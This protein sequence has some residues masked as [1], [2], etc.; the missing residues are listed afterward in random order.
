MD[1]L[2]ELIERHAVETGSQKAQKILQYWDQERAHF[3]QVCPIEM[4]DKLP[5]PLGI[6]DQAVPAE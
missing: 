2:E 5:A 4:L 1:E 6:E 3:L